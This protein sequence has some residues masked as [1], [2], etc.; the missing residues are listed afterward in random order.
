MMMGAIRDIFSQEGLSKSE[1]NPRRR[2]HALNFSQHSFSSILN[3]LK[4]E[5]LV[6][7]SGPKK[8]AEWS[9]TPKGLRVLS[10]IS[11]LKKPWHG[12]VRPAKL[13]PI[14]GIVRLV[15]FDVPE[16]EKP[17]RQWLRGEL[18][19]S[20]FEMLH[21]SVFIGNRPLPENFIQEL[22]YRNLSRYVHIVSLSQTGTLDG[23]EEHLKKR[24]QR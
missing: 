15:T 17:S 14:D 13:P 4:R 10:K 5:G 21:K 19:A 23:W 20:G 1:I 18:I 2:D 24:K 7:C 12:Y 6:T 3:R 9:I 16:K 8:K 11:S 22:D